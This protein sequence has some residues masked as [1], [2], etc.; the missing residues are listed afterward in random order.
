MIH[1]FE[2]IRSGSSLRDN[3]FVFNDE[4]H[5]S[6]AKDLGSYLMAAVPNATIIGFTGTPV[7]SSNVASG[8]FEIFGTRTRRATSIIIPS[9]SRSRMMN[10]PAD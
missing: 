9:L 8:S 1:K 10:H 6:V 5:R 3:I 4:A 2:Q 7:A